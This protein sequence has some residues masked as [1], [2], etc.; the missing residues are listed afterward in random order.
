[1]PC[2]VPV[3]VTVES[4]SSASVISVLPGLEVSSSLLKPLP[5]LKDEVSVSMVSKDMICSQ[6]PVE[7]SA[8]YPTNEGNVVIVERRSSIKG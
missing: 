2:A 7:V 5:G 3:N 4:T 6:G 1:M 8:K